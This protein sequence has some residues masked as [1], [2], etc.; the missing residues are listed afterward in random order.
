M[1]RETLSTLPGAEI[2]FPGLADLA[3]GRESANASAVQSAA[4]RLRKVGLSAPVVE[5]G[6][7]ASHQL[8]RQLVGEVG[9]RA[10]YAR[11]NAILER[12]ASFARAAELAQR[13]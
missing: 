10:A 9:E 12:V 6:P 7:P 2:V 13:G 4:V 1:S 3:A 8:Y 5:N 11:Y